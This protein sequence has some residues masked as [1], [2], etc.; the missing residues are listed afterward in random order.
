MAGQLAAA[1]FGWT[2]LAGSGLADDEAAM[3][4]DADVDDVKQWEQDYVQHS[5]H[6]GALCCPA[7]GR[8]SL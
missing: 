8:L 4:D 2:D 6:G 7:T 3:L 1:L 5:S